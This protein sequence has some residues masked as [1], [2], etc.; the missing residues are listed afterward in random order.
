MCNNLYN[1]IYVIFFLVVEL[2]AQ[3]D[4]SLKTYVLIK[5]HKAYII[6]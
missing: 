2:T 3:L 6:I 4:C 1:Q 5:R